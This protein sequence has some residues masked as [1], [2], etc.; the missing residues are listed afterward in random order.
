MNQ[1]VS[2]C[3]SRSWSFDPPRGYSDHTVRL[4]ELIRGRE[5]VVESRLTRAFIRSAHSSNAEGL[6]SKPRIVNAPREFQCLAGLNLCYRGDAIPLLRT[7]VHP[8]LF[9]CDQ[10]PNGP[11]EPRASATG[12]H[13]T[14]G[15]AAPFG[16]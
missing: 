10:R 6:A 11:N 12:S 16:G 5:G 2:V 3:P 7:D 15:A 14:T 4:A 13:R 1:T 9:V 8:S